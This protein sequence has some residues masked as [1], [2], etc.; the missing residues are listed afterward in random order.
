MRSERVRRKIGAA[1]EGAAS[2]PSTGTAVVS[3]SAGAVGGAVGA[4]ES[5]SS[6]AG[7][8]PQQRLGSAVEAGPRLQSCVQHASA[9]SSAAACIAVPWVAHRARART[10]PTL[11]RGSRRLLTSSTLHPASSMC[12]VAAPGRFRPG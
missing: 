4:A 11:Q 7:E 6:T 2:G 9:R 5:A 3:T 1:R 10:N 8:T 12:N